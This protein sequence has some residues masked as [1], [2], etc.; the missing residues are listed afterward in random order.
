MNN[1]QEVIRRMQGFRTPIQKVKE[2][3]GITDADLANT[4]KLKAAGVKHNARLA[5]LGVSKELFEQMFSEVLDFN[6][7]END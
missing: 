1:T 5:E 4:K 3:Y 7:T 2:F 6:Q